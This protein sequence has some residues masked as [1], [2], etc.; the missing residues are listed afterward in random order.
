MS[1]EGLK[2]FAR[3]HKLGL[4]E[5]CMKL[6]NYI[7]SAGPDIQFSLKNESFFIDRLLENSLK[8]KF[9]TCKLEQVWP[10]RFE[11]KHVNMGCFR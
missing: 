6:I 11:I 9:F 7:K 8:V 4:E 3:E 1:T 10:F 2:H 5:Y